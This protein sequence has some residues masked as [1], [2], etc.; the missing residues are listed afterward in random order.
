MASSVAGRKPV[1]A[2]LKPGAIAAALAL[3]A[4]GCGVAA[5]PAADICSS[6][7]VPPTAS[8][9]T[10]GAGRVGEEPVGS[11]PMA[12]SV[13]ID[14]GRNCYAFYYSGN[15]A[16]E[17]YVS[18]DMPT[19]LSFGQVGTLQRRDVPI[20]LVV[21][22]PRAVTIVG[23]RFLPAG[24]V[25]E[26]PIEREG[27][28]YRRYRLDFTHG[29][30][31]YRASVSQLVATTTLPAGTRAM[32]YY[33]TE[34]GGRLVHERRLPLVSVEI[35]AVPPLRRLP[36][37]LDTFSGALAAFPDPRAFHRL[38]FNILG[39]LSGDAV[40]LARTAAAGELAPMDW[41]TEHAAGAGDWRAVDRAGKVTDALC[42]TYRGPALDA[43][44]RHG[45]ALLDAGVFTHVAD[46]ERH[47]GE[48][49]C[50][51]PRDVDTFRQELATRAPEL[52]PA[53]PRF[54]ASRGT[55]SRRLEGEWAAFKARQYAD[56]LGWYAERMRAHIRDRGL[57]GTFR[58]LL[59]AN[60]L[61][62]PTPAPGQCAAATAQA[63][64][65]LIANS[66]QDPR[67]LDA[68]V[69]YYAPMMYL[70]VEGRRARRVD[71]ASLTPRLHCLRAYHQGPMRVM[72]ALSPGYPFTSLASE[73]PAPAMAYQVLEAFASGAQGVGIYDEGSF[74][75][76]GM[77]YFALA[78][79]QVAKV[80]R[81]F[82]DGAPIAETALADVNH[83]TF[84]K[85]VR[86]GHEAAVLVSEYSRRSRVARVRYAGDVPARVIDLQ[87]DRVV[88][89]LDHERREFEVTLAPDGERARLFLVDES[90]SRP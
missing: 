44:V 85:G 54:F 63:L 13:V 60:S 58:W 69:T 39:G 74:D 25:T 57:R 34:M 18:T 50:F 45:E 77:R 8:L 30:Y 7:P 10:P 2:L 59:Y 88:A 67:A 48:G 23:G 15:Y 46:P 26:S 20:D 90:R 79:R 29:R 11:V 4:G 47:D 55:G 64:G 70:D 32:A 73:M 41:N 5:R 68:A 19:Y 65:A 42:P 12:A 62:G 43:W 21:D 37:F 53:L 83:Q 24:H 89:L 78:M 87:D 75:G 81:V 56:L 9:A 72:P 66:M 49:I 28:A 14:P 76:L 52:L 38:G 71:L 6:V 84:V 27:Q 1:V 33:A 80:E 61:G 31:A 16:H 3:A 22:V 82:A 36:V 86:A 35:E 51:H 40:E 17:A